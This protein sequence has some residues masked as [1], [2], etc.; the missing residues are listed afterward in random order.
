MEKII[1]LAVL[2]VLPLAPQ[3]IKYIAPP[4]EPLP[5]QVV[6]SEGLTEEALLTKAVTYADK[7]QVSRETMVRKIKCE[8]PIME[9]DGVRYYD[10][11]D[12]QSRLKYSEGQIAR[13]PDWGVVGEREKSFGPAQIH[14][15]A[16][17]EITK[18]QASDPDFA[19]NFMAE[20]LS[21]GQ[22]KWT[23]K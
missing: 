4:L 20:H 7:Y 11:K 17:P 3:E 21:K 19:L 2:A 10:H 16:H 5:V 22:D 12:P 23:C 18:E 13:N 8:A 6:L 14:L 15:P 1:T 9:K